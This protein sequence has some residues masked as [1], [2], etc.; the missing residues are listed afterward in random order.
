MFAP[1][2]ASA[3]ENQRRNS[4]ESIPVS[5][6]QNQLNTAPTNSVSTSKTNAKLIVNP[7]AGSPSASGGATTQWLGV[8]KTIV[9]QALRYGG[10]ALG[11]LIKKIPY[12]WA[13]KA[14]ESIGR[15]GN[16]AA[17]VLEKIN[18][19]AEN[20]VALALTKAGIPPSDAIYIA[21]FIAF[22]L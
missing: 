21:K 11:Q 4:V 2:F 1:S 5:V 12:S 17:N 20:S 22:F 18:N 9:I 15:W 13:N 7:V 6:S 19:F 10:T 3:A 8:T 14:G 16:K